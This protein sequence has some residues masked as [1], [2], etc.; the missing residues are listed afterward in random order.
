MNQITLRD[1]PVSFKVCDL[2]RFALCDFILVRVF[3]LYYFSDRG[4]F[5]INPI[6]K[7]KSR[8]KSAKINL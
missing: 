8:K 5:K 3:L 1:R 4:W 2:N 7:M 6:R